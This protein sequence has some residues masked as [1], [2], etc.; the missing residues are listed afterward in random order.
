MTIP[1]GYMA[2]AHTCEANPY[3]PDTWSA[4]QL[5]AFMRWKAQHIAARH[6]VRVA[7][8]TW[9]LYS[10]EQRISLLRDDLAMLESPPPTQPYTHCPCHAQPR[11]LAEE[12]SLP[13]DRVSDAEREQWV[14]QS[15]FIRSG[16]DKRTQAC[17]AWLEREFERKDPSRRNNPVNA[18]R[19][20]RAR[21][22]S[23]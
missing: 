7:D 8:G 13:E 23:N 18:D 19:R 3:H 1:A 17:L 2:W 22:R 6:Q 12:Q 5:E 16:L 10:D 14:A 4:E 20:L 9:A 15:P 11:A 21:P